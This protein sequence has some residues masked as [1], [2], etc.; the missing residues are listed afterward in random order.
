LVDGWMKGRRV[1]V[2]RFG[3][4]MVMLDGGGKEWMRRKRIFTIYKFE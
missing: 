2:D 3:Y 4:G 1:N